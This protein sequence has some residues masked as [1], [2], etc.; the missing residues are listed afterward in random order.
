MQSSADARVHAIVAA[1]R[2]DWPGIELT[3]R[4]EQAI[5]RHA[6][7]SALA[8]VDP[9]EVYLALACL[10]DSA[11]AMRLFERRYLASAEPALATYRLGPDELLE[12][13]QR[14]RIRLFVQQ[15]DGVPVI[16]HYAGQ[17]RLGGLVRVVLVR[18]AVRLRS[19]ATQAALTIEA[20][21][22]RDPELALADDERQALSKQ[23][24]ERAA[25]RLS[26][27]ERCLLRLHYV[28][29]VSGA[30]I[31]A[32]YGVHRATAV[33]WLE[34]ARLHLLQHLSTELRTLAP[35][36]SPA[37]REQLETWFDTHL[38]LSLS[39]VL[40]TSSS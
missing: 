9:A 4:L 26:G 37:Q 17:G 31:A 29:S 35:N 24:F 18:E 32:M 7:T 38:E 27:R 36:L 28:R 15:R 5:E 2:R 13:R 33:R 3:P 14:V 25:A 23:A 6:Q 11:A 21:E 20:I 16:L 34:S 40:A 10:E 19:A 8:V 22:P 39:R 1:G 12:V 30:A